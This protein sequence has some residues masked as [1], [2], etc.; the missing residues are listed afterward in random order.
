M[1]SKM[2]GKFKSIVA[3]CLVAA[4]FSVTAVT[5]FAGETENLNGKGA[6]WSGGE[7]DAGMIYSK[8][9]DNKEGGLKYKVTVWVDPD[10]GAKKSKTGTTT[11]VGND[12]RVFISTEATHKYPGFPEKMGYKDFFGACGKVIC[13]KE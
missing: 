3:G 11:A 5:A 9:V 13:V 10:K 1:V 7:T 12:G 4:V 6:T 8:L 2:K